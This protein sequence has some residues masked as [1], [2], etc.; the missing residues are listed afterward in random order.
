MSIENVEKQNNLSEEQQEKLE[1][2]FDIMKKISKSLRNGNE[3]YETILLVD[4]FMKKFENN[5]ENKEKGLRLENYALGRVLLF[6]KTDV[7]NWQYFD[8]KDGQIEKFII[9][10]HKNILN[11]K[12][13]NEPEKPEDKDNKINKA[14]L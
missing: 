8:T 7:S 13:E 4:D 14:I 11:K 1:E 5:E 3:A 6:S 2:I 9:K 10:L 12:G